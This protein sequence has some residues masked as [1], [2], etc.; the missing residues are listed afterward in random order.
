[1]RLGQEKVEVMVGEPGPLLGQWLPCQIRS[2]G[3]W[4]ATYHVSL[5][6]RPKKSLANHHQPMLLNVC[7]HVFWTVCYMKLI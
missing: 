3:D 1:M 6:P 4:P 7:K 5:A 2:P